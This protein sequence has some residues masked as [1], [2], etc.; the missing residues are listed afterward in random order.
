MYRNAPNGM[1][2]VGAVA[3]PVDLAQPGVTDGNELER[4]QTAKVREEE[5]RKGIVSHVHQKTH[6]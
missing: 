6:P 5:V 4:E 1:S 2:L 3:E